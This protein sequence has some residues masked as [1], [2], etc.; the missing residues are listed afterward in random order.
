MSPTVVKISGQARLIWSV[1]SSRKL[2]AL[3]FDD[4]PVPNATPLVL[5]ALD[6]TG[7]SATFFL[8]GS[9]LEANAGLIEGRLDRHEVGNHTWSHKDLSTLDWQGNFDEI[10]KSHQSI[11]KHLGIEP[12]IFRP[13]FGHIGTLTMRAADRFGYDFIMW[14]QGVTEKDFVE[15]PDAVIPFVVDNMVPGTIFLAHDA[16]APGIDPPFLNRLV[17][18]IEKLKAQGYEFV[19]VSELMAAGQA[20]AATAKVTTA[21]S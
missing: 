16:V 8:V 15:K 12:K 4:G 3:T 18:I 6:K 14:S 9:R 21:P 20:H 7:V 11:V 13:P 5:D 10:S 17:D 1:E 19:T 2:V